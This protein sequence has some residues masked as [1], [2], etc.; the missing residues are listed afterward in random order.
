MSTASV[1]PMQAS[2]A[3]SASN[4]Q[5]TTNISTVE[6]VLN[7]EQTITSSTTTVNRQINVQQ[8]QSSNIPYFSDTTFQAAAKS[9]PKPVDE[10]KPIETVSCFSAMKNPILD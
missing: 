6:S 7:R 10:P 1:M 3:F 2:D 5:H 9:S 8:S 4:G